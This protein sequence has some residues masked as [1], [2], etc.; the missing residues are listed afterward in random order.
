MKEFTFVSTPKMIDLFQA[1]EKKKNTVQT[2][3]DSTMDVILSENVKYSD[4]KYPAPLK[5]KL[6]EKADLLRELPK[7]FQDL[8]KCKGY[9]NYEDSVG[10]IIDEAVVVIYL[11]KESTEDVK[12]EFR[13]NRAQA[14][15]CDL[16]EKAK[17]MIVT[18]GEKIPP[19]FRHMERS[20]IDLAM[21]INPTD[22]IKRINSSL[23]IHLPEFK[24]SPVIE[25]LTKPSIEKSEGATSRPATTP[26]KAAKKSASEG[27]KRCLIS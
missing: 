10:S 12:I 24:A 2:L 25:G 8:A 11:P 4:A 19:E 6:D 21:G 13:K 3:E 27:K 18:D 1:L 17:F 9:F 23:A 7:P 14:R 22:T 26:S 16:S 5:S 15:H 20:H